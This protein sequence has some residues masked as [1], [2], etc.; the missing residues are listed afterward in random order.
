MNSGR[1]QIGNRSNIYILINELD[2]VIDGTVVLSHC[3]TV[4]EV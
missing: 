1:V 2:L 4:D 3:K